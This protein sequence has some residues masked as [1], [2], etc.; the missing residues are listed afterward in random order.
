M[1]LDDGEH[2]IDARFR[3]QVP[4]RP[5]RTDHH[6]AAAVAPGPQRTDEQHPEG[7]RVNV[8]DPAQVDRCSV[9]VESVIALALRRHRGQVQVADHAEHVPFT[10]RKDADVE[11]HRS[12][13]SATTAVLARPRCSPGVGSPPTGARFGRHPR[14][15]RQ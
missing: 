5:R 9:G 2:R 8:V 14:A 3:Q 15:G 12:T 4:C 10:H 6:E 1:V 11:Q 7:D 13:V